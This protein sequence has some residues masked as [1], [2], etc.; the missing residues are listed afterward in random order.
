MDLQQDIMR[1]SM[2]NQGAHR[3]GR[4]VKGGIKYGRVRFPG[5][6]HVGEVCCSDTFLPVGSSTAGNFPWACSR[7]DCQ[8]SLCLPPTSW[9][10]GQFPRRTPL[11]QSA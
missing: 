8:H 11:T 2:K 7:D 4:A 10:D 9:L 1:A 6:V 3:T 5:P